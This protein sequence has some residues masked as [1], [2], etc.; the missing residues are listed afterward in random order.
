MSG[1]F[2]FNPVP[3]M[4]DGIVWAG[5][6]LS[7][8]WVFYLLYPAV[9]IFSNNKKIIVA[10]WGGV[11]ISSSIAKVQAEPIEIN[12]NILNHMVFFISGIFVYLY[13]KD[14]QRLNIVLGKYAGMISGIIIF[15]LAAFLLYCFSQ[16]GYPF[17]IYIAYSLVWGG[18]NS[19]SIIGMPSF[20]NNRLTRF[21][22]KAS[23]NIYL[24]HGIVLY[25][26]KA[27]GMY[28]WIDTLV[29]S[30]PIKFLISFSITAAVT[31]GV[32]WLSYKFI[33][34]P[35]IDL[36]KRFIAKKVAFVPQPERPYHS[37]VFW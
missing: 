20:I 28:Q 25:L 23:Y 2:L 24:M 30:V 13:L 26:M 6:S 34:K 4:Q 16:D 3:K 10:L 11:F 27:F 1:T 36:G 17:N 32:S 33:E 21:L 12:M 31:V 14:L 22:G 5:W 15:S 9:F 29:V 7:I 18:M 37:K 8:E 19:A 35:G